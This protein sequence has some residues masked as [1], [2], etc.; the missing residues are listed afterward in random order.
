L[1]SCGSVV[2]YGRFPRKQCSGLIAGGA[3][4]GLLLAIPQANVLNV[5][6]FLPEA[7]HESMI[8]G[9]VAFAV[10]VYMLYHVGRRG[11]G[12]RRDGGLPPP[13]PPATQLRR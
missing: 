13:P 2:Q 10:L 7:L 1:L 12:G 3:I 5:G 8:I 11:L 9:L 4:A 6:R